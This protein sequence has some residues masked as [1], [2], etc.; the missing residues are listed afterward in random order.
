M[1]GL[2]IR[3]RMHLARKCASC[4][5]AVKV[6]MGAEIGRKHKASSSDGLAHPAMKARIEKD[7]DQGIAKVQTS[8]RDLVKAHKAQA[9]T[10]TDDLTN[11]PLTST[12][13]TTKVVLDNKKDLDSCV[14]RAI[15]RAGLPVAA[16]EH[17]AFIK[18]L[19]RM[20]SAYDPPR[21][22]VLAASA[23]DLEYAE[24]QSRLQAEMRDSSLVSIGVESWAVS[25][26]CILVSCLI[27]RPKPAVFSIESTGV[28][29]PTPAVLVKTIHNTI[30]QVGT[31]RVSVIVTDTTDG[32]KQASLMLQDQYS[33][34]TILPSCAYVM[35]Q[36][37]T[38]ILG[39]RTIARTLDICKK[40]AGFFATDHLARGSFLRV[41][42]HMHFVDEIAPMG[43]PDDSSPIGL[44][45]CLFKVERG[46]HILDILLAENGTMNKLIAQAKEEIITLA[47]WKDVSLF[48]E[49]LGPFLEILKMFEAD[50]PLLST[51]Y[52]QF[53][54]LWAHLNKFEELA[55]KLQPIVTGYWET[56]QHPAIYAAY[57]L[58]PRFPL[59]NLTGEATSEALAYIK[60]TSNVEAYGTI[61]DELTRFTARTGLFADD[62]IWESAQKCSPL[63]WWKG[64]IGSSCPNLQRVAML[65][66][67]FPISSG[68]PKRKREI[69][70]RILLMNA[71]YM[72]EAQSS[73]AAVV[74]LNS[75]LVSSV[76][77]NSV[78]SETHV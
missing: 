54:L 73:K 60:R 18:M 71:Q 41:S 52:H 68:L 25:Q 19:K 43:D 74:C 34:I 35:N 8:S 59:S 62:A 9:A 24:V 67:S 40:L 14:A 50:S 1:C 63:H 65:T 78:S 44:L 28:M 12:P 57:L 36:M 33:G 13:L 23:L 3:M 55:S 20:N 49:L 38:E 6:E 16:V 2:V 27:N 70:K 15:F 29:P 7:H 11:L 58:D 21:V 76:E 69:F 77:D 51:F 22:S 46:R 37:M 30:T 64:F 10:D 39:M 26:K 66:L 75:T 4:P 45:E 47:F 42:E 61:V 53:T 48:T 72:S 17:W 5:E 31:G 56:I 32:M